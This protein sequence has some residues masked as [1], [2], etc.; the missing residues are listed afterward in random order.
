MIDH[1]FL[2]GIGISPSNVKFK[3]H[4]ENFSA[5]RTPSPSSSPVAPVRRL[6]KSFSV[7]ASSSGIHKGR[8]PGDLCIYIQLS[9]LYPIDCSQIVALLCRFL[10]LISW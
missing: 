1:A 10:S 2:L 8:V 6:A 5:D 3:E 7:A 9:A 4:V